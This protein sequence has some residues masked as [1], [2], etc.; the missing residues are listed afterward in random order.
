MRDWLWFAATGVAVIARLRWQLG[1]SWQ[2]AAA[3]AV[4]FG[5][6]AVLVV[7][8]VRLLRAL[9]SDGQRVRAMHV[10]GPLPFV[11]MGAC[12]LWAPVMMLVDGGARLESFLIFATDALV[13]MGYFMWVLA[14][15]PDERR[16]HTPVAKVDP[17]EKS[18][19]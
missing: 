15:H 19:P 4:G 17:F 14:F 9:G 11:G 8:S 7:R 6:L 16:D 12:A 5:V 2:T 13:G 18:A 1:A 3:V 10:V